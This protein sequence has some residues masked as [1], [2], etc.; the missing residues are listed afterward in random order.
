M[1][2]F[3]LRKNV[4]RFRNY[5]GFNNTQNQE[6]NKMGKNNV[7]QKI[8]FLSTLTFFLLFYFLF[9]SVLRLLLYILLGLCIYNVSPLF[10]SQSFMVSFPSPG[11]KN[12]SL[13]NMKKKIHPI[14]QA[15]LHIFE[16]KLYI[17]QYFLII[18]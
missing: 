3:K 13:L 12:T 5:Y 1:A 11:V 2:N 8:L 7:Y 16:N 10:I 17:E 14:N 4:I 15:N 9:S 6:S 18:Q